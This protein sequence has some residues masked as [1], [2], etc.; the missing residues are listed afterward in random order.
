MAHPAFAKLF[1]ETEFVPDLGAILATRRRRSAGDPQVWAAHLAVVEGESSGRC[2]VR[3]RSRALSRAGAN[4][5]HRRPP[6]PK[7]GRCP[8][9]WAPCSIRSSACAGA[10]GFRA[11]QRRASRSGRWPPPSREDVLDLADKH[12]DPMAF[13][14]ATTLAWTQAQMQLHHLGIVTDEAH[15]FQRLAN[16][17]L[18]SDPTLRPPADVLKRGAGK[19]STLW[20]QGI[21]GDLPIVLVRVE[22]DG[23]SRTRP[24][25]FARS[26]ILAVETAGRRS[27]DP[28]RARRVLCPGFAELARR[29]GAHEPVDARDRGRR[30]A[31]GACS[32]CAPISSRPKF[33]A[34]FT[35]ARARCCTATAARLADQIKRARDLKPASAPPPG[36]RA[37]AG[38]GARNAVAAARD[39]VLQRARRL[40]E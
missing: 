2:A 12:H 17:V 8:I 10:C 13:D 19:A 30:S 25:A 14:R 34:C 36:R 21:S 1:V 9:P 3:D 11:A 26:R 20:A 16:H 37:A 22:E 31:R 28:E 18:Y 4:H 23:R 15:L 32:S 29:A 5:S 6:S 40:H 38:R 39:G 33:A 24:P 27:G 7:A 35:P